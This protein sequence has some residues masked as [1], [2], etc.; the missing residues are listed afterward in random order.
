MYGCVGGDL[1]VVGGGGGGGGG[2]ESRRFFKRERDH[3]FETHIHIH[4]QTLKTFDDAAK[5][6]DSLLK[7]ICVFGS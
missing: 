2:G 7:R 3:A 1:L 6:E 4:W 5:T